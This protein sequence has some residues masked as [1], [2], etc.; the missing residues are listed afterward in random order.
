MKNNLNDFLDIKK[1]EIE[2]E[3]FSIKDNLLKFSDLTIQLSNISYLSAGKKKFKIPIM[4]IIILIISLFLLSILPIFGFL[5]LIASGGYIWYLYN[6]YQKEKQF[7]TF[8]LN[9]GQIYRIS[10]EKKD[11][12]NK[13]RET[14]E[15]SMNNKNKNFEINI[16]KQEV[17]SGDYHSHNVR[18]SNIKISSNSHQKT[19]SSVKIGDIKDSS[20]SGVAFG[21]NNIVRNKEQNISYNWAELRTNLKSLLSNVSEDSSL[22]EASIQAL[23]AAEKEDKQQFEIVIQN[24]KSIFLS[25]LFQNTASQFLVQIINNILG[26]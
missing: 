13:V 23:Q 15:F 8:N 6:D 18:G 25:N 22:T 7:L 24:N 4:A 2:T 16:G 5:L 3:E 19:D 21:S 12:L 14:V 1:N 11:F 10:F 17:F 26:I 9:S 20:M